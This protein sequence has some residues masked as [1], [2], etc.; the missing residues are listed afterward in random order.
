MK[1]NW[2]WDHHHRRCRCRRRRR[3]HHEHFVL[4]VPAE[5]VCH[6]IAWLLPFYCTKQPN[7]IDIKFSSVCILSQKKTLTACCANF[8]APRWYVRHWY[9]CVCVCAIDM[10]VRVCRY[11]HEKSPLLRS[12]LFEIGEKVLLNII[13]SHKWTYSVMCALAVLPQLTQK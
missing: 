13:Y 7:K 12:L 4:L 11:L 3:C 5:H 10:C 2:L 6:F 9:V 8:G 1:S